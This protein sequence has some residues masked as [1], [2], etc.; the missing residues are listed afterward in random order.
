MRSY[1]P[2]IIIKDIIPLIKPHILNPIWDRVCMCIIYIVLAN[3]LMHLV[4]CILYGV[5][6]GDYGI[7]YNMITWLGLQRP[8]TLD[9]Q[10][11]ACN[12]CGLEH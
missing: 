4:T 8:G 2:P 3:A 1:C 6:K 12:C 5:N 9:P 7:S 10:Q 11:I